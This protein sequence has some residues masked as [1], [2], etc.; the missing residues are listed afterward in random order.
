MELSASQLAQVKAI[1]N[2][3]TPEEKAGQ[4]ILTD[5]RFLETPGD[6][7]RFNLGGIFVNGGGAPPPNTIDSWILLAEKMQHHGRKSSLAIPLLL[8]TDA[9]HG[10]NNFHGAV[11][12]PH[13]IGLGAGNNPLLV[14]EISRITSLE[15]AATGFNWNFAPCAAVVDDPRWG[16]TY[17]CYSSD[18]GIVSQLAAAAVRGVQTNFGT[19]KARVLACAKHF[20]GD[21]GTAGGVD[22]GNTNIG[23]AELRARFLPPYEAAIA[24][25]VGSIMLSYNQWNGT[26]CH[27]SRTLIT[28]LLKNELGFKGLV[29][30]DWDAIE[31]LAPKDQYIDAISISINAGLDM[32]MASRKYKTCHEG[33]LE[34]MSKGDIPLSRIN[35]A[36]ERILTTKA[37][38]GLLDA[39]RPELPSKIMIGCKEHRQIAR[40]AV[41]ESLVL[42]KNDSILPLGSKFKQIHICGEFADDIGLQ[43]GGWSISWQGSKGKITEGTTIMEGIRDQAPM[44]IEISYSKEATVADGTDLVIAVAGE[45]PYAEFHGD[46]Q[47]LGFPQDQEAFLSSLIKFDIPVLLILITG[48]PLIITPNL[49]NVEAIMAA[50]LPGTEGAGIA[51]VLFSQD[52][53]TGRLPTNWPSVL[54]DYKN[55]K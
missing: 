38:L 44:G 50:W 15:L 8:G 21:G 17:E 36:V 10:N 46:S 18:T 45:Y 9:V 20:I 19:G 27:G 33:L 52:I 4:M 7:S 29:V 55:S 24:A 5:P 12:F 42:L 43:C 23:L 31:Y 39:Q 14:E 47:D 32:I 22:R 11:L 16:R 1:I 2:R 26:Y 49:N 28:D 41:Q 34:L 40:K 3:M 53:P 54:E 13:N 6:I 30:S 25:G 35:D 48:R 37:A 51:D